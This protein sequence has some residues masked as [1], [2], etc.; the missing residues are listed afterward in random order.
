M[1]LTVLFAAGQP[2]FDAYQTALEQAFQDHAL[3]VRLVTDAPPEQVDY[4]IYAPSSP[5]QDFTP[6]T[7]CKAV[8]NLWA[9]VEKIVGNPTLTQPLC[10]MVDPALTQGMVEYVC[11]HVLRYHLGMDAHIHAR[12]GDW[13]PVEP[14]LRRNAALAFWGWAHWGWRWRRRWAVSGLTFTAGRAAQIRAGDH[15]PSW[16][17]GVGSLPVAR[18]DSG[19]VAAPD[20]GH[21]KPA[22]CA[23]ISDIAKRG[24]A[25]QSGSRRACG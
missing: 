5:L 15:L 14:R 12:P 4:I 2:L 7:A 25:Y 24:G 9:G 20:K 23:D 10:R 17:E 21:G 8:L 22:G 11:G 19:H 6:Y 1:T 16:A 13:Q 18:A 3:N